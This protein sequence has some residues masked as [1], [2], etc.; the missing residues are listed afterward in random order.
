MSEYKFLAYAAIGVLIF[1]Y[2]AWLKREK[3]E[4]RGRSILHK[5][6]SGLLFVGAVVG[7]L[8]LFIFKG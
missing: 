3:A 5:D 7:A 1:G 4:G 8:L 6:I 2:R